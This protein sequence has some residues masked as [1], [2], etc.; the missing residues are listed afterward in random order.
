[1]KGIKFF[2]EKTIKK[3]KHYVYALFDPRNCMPF[4][5]GKGFGNR[6]FNHVTKK[7]KNNEN[8]KYKTIIEIENKKMEVKHVIF[9]YGL[10]SKKEALKLESKLIDIF[11]FC[12][13]DLTNIQSGYHTP[14]NGVATTEDLIRKF[15]AK[16][17]NKMDSNAVILN[18]NKNY[19]RNFDKI[20]IYNAT[21]CCWAIKKDKIE[22]IDFVL[23][24]Y[25]GVIIEVF[26]VIKWKEILVNTNGKMKT[27]WEFEGMVARDAIRNLYLDKLVPSGQNPVRLNI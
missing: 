1:M 21:K 6:V 18:I 27:R 7:L 2:D 19:K 20:E 23:S 26:E 4:Y 17:L 5:I 15:N 14:D 12:K 8:L 3:V 22:N 24:S 9:G 25:R 10:E 16:K 13:I 11:R